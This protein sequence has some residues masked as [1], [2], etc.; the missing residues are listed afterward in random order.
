VNALAFSG[1]GTLLAAGED[2]RGDNVQIFRVADA[3]PVRTLPG[4]PNGSVQGVAFAPGG[5]TL[6][7]SSGSSRVI[8][9]WNPVT[10]ELRTSLDQETGAG[11]VPLLPVAFSPDGTRLGYGRG[12]ATVAATRL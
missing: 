2:T 4:D 6:A 5:A 7:S 11:P 9:L 12:D 3:A 10:G 1:D 8:Q